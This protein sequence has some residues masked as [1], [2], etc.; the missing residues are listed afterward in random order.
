MVESTSASR[1]PPGIEKVLQR[2]RSLPREEKMQLLVSYAK[3]LEPVPERLASLDRTPFTVPECQTRVDLFP[4]FR[5]GR[6]RFYA[7]VDRRQSPT[8]AAFLAI[9]FSAINDEPPS[10]ALS[11][12]PDFV[13]LV[14][15]NIG[16]GAREFGLN[17]IVARVKRHASEALQSA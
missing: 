3:R 11:I 10:T 9:L 6:M 16:L 2:F 14:M 5:D 7:D 12:P 17:G 8:I 13:R 4:E 15:E 1:I